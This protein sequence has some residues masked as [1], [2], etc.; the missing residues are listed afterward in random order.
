MTVDADRYRSALATVPQPVAVVIARDLQGQ[1]FG[2]TATAVC[3]L[4]LNPPS[5]MVCVDHRT[6]S[7]DAMR[8]CDEFTVDFLAAEHRELARLFSTRGADRFGSPQV[9]SDDTGSLR[10]DQSLVHIGCTARQR[11]DAYDHLVV[12]GTVDFLE[13]RQGEPLLIADREFTVPIQWGL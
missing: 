3:S 2:F 9:V 13:I 1:P 8:T 7:R 4:S 11:F 6:S 12:V 10:I 5:L